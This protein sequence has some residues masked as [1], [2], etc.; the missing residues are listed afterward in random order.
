MS[1]VAKPTEI[2]TCR[3]VAAAVQKTAAA[4]WKQA[5]GRPVAE[6]DYGQLKKT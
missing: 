3:A 2:I 6:R 5:R 1:R 4:D